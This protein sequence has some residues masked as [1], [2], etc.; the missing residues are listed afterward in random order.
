[1]DFNKENHQMKDFTYSWGQSRD[2]YS[3]PLQL[4]QNFVPQ[5]CYNRTQV[6]DYLSTFP[7]TQELVQS[8]GSRFNPNSY[9]E[10]L[11]KKTERKSN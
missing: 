10:S 3:Q 4:Q 5:I 1:M 6:P 7:Q 9:S 11:K 2:K 8:F